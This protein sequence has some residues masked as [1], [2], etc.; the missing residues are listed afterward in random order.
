MLDLKDFSNGTTLFCAEHRV[1][2]IT[3]MAS[4][5][6]ILVFSFVAFLFPS[7]YVAYADFV[8][9]TIPLQHPLGASTLLGNPPLVL[10]G[11]AIAFNPEEG[12]MYIA[13]VTDPGR[14]TVIDVNTDTVTSSVE[15][16]EAGQTGI[17]FNPNNAVM[18]AANFGDDTV[19]LI[20]GPASGETF[21]ITNIDDGPIGI[22][23]SRDRFMYVANCEEG[24][25]Q[26]I[27]V[28]SVS[29][30]F[31]VRGSFY[32]DACPAYPAVAHHLGGTDVS[33]TQNLI[34]VP[35]PRQNVIFVI[36]ETPDGALGDMKIIDVPYT[37]PYAATYSQQK[38][39]IYVANLDGSVTII[40]A[41]TLAQ[42]GDV[43]ISTLQLGSGGAGGAGIAYNPNNDA[44]YVS[45]CNDDI[46]Y[47]FSW[48]DPAHPPSRPEIIDLSEPGEPVCP[49]GIA[50][51][52]DYQKMYVTNA[53]SNTV[54]V[55]R[56]TDFDADGDFILDAVDPSSSP[57]DEFEDIMDTPP[58]NVTTFGSIIDRGNQ[59]Y[60]S[61][62][63][64]PDPEGVIVKSF[65][66]TGKES[67]DS[68]GPG[69][70]SAITEIPPGSVYP[71]TCSDYGSRFH[72]GPVEQGT[73]P[74]TLVADDRRTAHLE[75]PTGNSISFNFAS[76]AVTAASSNS[77]TLTIRIE[78]TRELP[79]A[80][81]ETLIIDATLHRQQ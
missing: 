75:V 73:V 27:S 34:F 20:G 55:I 42:S 6:L 72:L 37:E 7:K 53:A 44:I 43:N 69:A 15:L 61:I 65:N 81:G 66:T 68:C 40:E 31:D 11:G 41:L 16:D 59:T 2:L 62:G 17:A 13:H 25:I 46:V 52:N 47:K 8:E 50:F 19:S 63:E 32:P 28:T 14:Y 79:L 26:Q 58:Y 33:L 57:S 36:T 51:N 45:N 10:R 29:A 80:P 54:S 77:A 1:L 64:A 76:G 9:K 67:I 24:N 12:N 18:Y 74:T 71:I 22:A 39:A 48:N 78:G 35:S 60:F 3:L 56:T 70:G 49:F 30:T 23:S 4:L 21:R 38:H 5:A